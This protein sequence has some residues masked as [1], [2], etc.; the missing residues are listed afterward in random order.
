MMIMI[1]NNQMKIMLH[2]NQII[3]NSKVRTW[4]VLTFFVSMIE[5][6]FYGKNE[7]TWSGDFR[8]E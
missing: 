2:K 7:R 4:S 5:E 1:M 6:T 8:A 3:T